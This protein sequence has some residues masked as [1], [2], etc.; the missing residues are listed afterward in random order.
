M[1]LR[2][3]M[4][5]TE[6]GDRYVFYDSVTFYVYAAVF[7]TENIAWEFAEWVREKTGRSFNAQKEPIHYQLGEQFY[8]EVLKPRGE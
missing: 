2:L 8:D 1:A 7:K 5:L 3:G 6:D 4:F